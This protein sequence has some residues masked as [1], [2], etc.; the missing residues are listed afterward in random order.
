MRKLYGLII[1][2][3]IGI[4][5]LMLHNPAEDVNSGWLNYWDA[6]SKS[7]ETGKKLFIFISSP[8][9]PVCK[10]F[11]DSLSKEEVMRKI[12]EKFLPVYIKDPKNSPVPVISFPTFCIGY[13]G[14]LK[15]FYSSSVSSLLKELGVN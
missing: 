7:N 6:V 2:A 12:S 11:K 5:V 13:V 1:V 3:V 4:A 8:T 10:E 14:E 15:C 9:C